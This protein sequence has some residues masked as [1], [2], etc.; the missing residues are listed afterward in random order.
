MTRKYIG[1]TCPYCKT[2]LVKGDTVVFCSVCDMPHHLSCWQDNQGCTTFG[3]TGTMKEIIGGDSKVEEAPAAP[4]PM[5][6]A[7]P[8]PAPAPAP[9]E[10]AVETLWEAK[11]TVFMADVPIVMENAAIIIDRAKD[12][13]FAHCTFRSLTDKE[14]KAVLI[15]VSC[16]DVWGETLGE[17]I[18]FQYLDLRTE[19][20]SK[21]GQTQPIELADKTTR[22]IQVSVKKVLFGDDRVVSGGGEAFTMPAPV[23]LSQQLESKELAQEYARETSPKA[24]FVPESANGYWRCACGALNTEDEEK[25]HCCGCTKEQLAAALDPAAL[26]AN[27]IAFAAKKKAAAQKQEERIR[28][29]QEQVRLEQEEK[30]RQIK[31]AEDQARQ[32]KRKKKTITTVVISLVV[33]LLLSF[34]IGFFG[35]RYY[36]YRVA[37]DLLEQKQYDG[38][39]QGFVALGGFLDSAE[40]A[41]EALYRKAKAAL[42]SEDY[43]GAI[44]IFVNLGSYKDSTDQTLEAKYRKAEKLQEDKK[45]KEAYE[46]FKELGDY[47]ESKDALL[48]T[49]V[50]WET[51]LLEKS[52]TADLYIFSNTVKLSADQREV[53]YTTLLLHI[54]EHGDAGYWYGGIYSKKHAKAVQTMLNMLPSRYEDTATLL[55]LFKLLANGTG[56]DEL[57]QDNESVMRQCWSLAFVQNIAKD[58]SA[59]AYFLEGYWSTYGD[60]YYISFYEN[61]RGGISSQ[62]N[63]PHVLQ[64]NGTKYYDIWSLTYVYINENNVELTKVFRFEI[65][66]YDTIKVYCFKNNRT[67]TL[68]RE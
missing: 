24:Q 28:A 9:A 51:H 20:E 53:F 3:C 25:C 15:E 8:K 34:G 22:K 65:V 36:N 11:E 60:D 27:M 57:F 10:Q 54:A 19:R 32:K 23:L 16:Q 37:C 61:D 7:E 18:A 56:P 47:K 29:A 12:K 13:L 52:A 6:A 46:L 17:P 2:P 35:V 42:E 5:P 67:Y 63:L 43:D 21:F 26:Q 66:D 39:H 68:Y 50:L 1:K 55:K 33:V 58:D 49:I 38:A 4:Q 44:Q 31:L 30:D 41:N 40:M 59:I 45:Y 48:A 14:I 62:Y 64:P